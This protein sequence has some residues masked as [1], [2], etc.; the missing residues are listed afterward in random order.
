MT[1][2]THT[3]RAYWG[4]RDVSR[5]PTQQRTVCVRETTLIIKL[6]LRSLAHILATLR[7]RQKD[8]VVCNRRAFAVNAMCCIESTT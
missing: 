3:V 5:M 2:I 7:L 6:T 1:K 4:L 8:D